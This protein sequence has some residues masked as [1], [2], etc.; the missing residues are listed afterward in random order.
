MGE[1]NN[2]MGGDMTPESFGRAFAVS[3]IK[4]PEKLMEL[5][6]AYGPDLP[7]DTIESEA[8]DEQI[9]VAYGRIVAVAFPF[10]ASLATT[11]KVLTSQ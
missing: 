2:A 9:A 11:R 7:R 5:V 4:F 6:M 8:T 10:L 1:V 3:M